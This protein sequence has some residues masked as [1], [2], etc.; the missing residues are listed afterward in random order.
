MKSIFSNITDSE[1]ETLNWILYNDGCFPADRFFD[2]PTIDG[3]ISELT[4]CGF[5]ILNPD[6]GLH[7]T[8]LG[9][10]ALDEYVQL[11]KANRKRLFWEWFRFLL[12]TIIA[13][14][15]LIVSIVK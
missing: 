6:T 3:H 5:V 9:R 11:K 15:S 12:P 8:E 1:Y 7:I 10:A 13:L 4:T 14:I 2:D